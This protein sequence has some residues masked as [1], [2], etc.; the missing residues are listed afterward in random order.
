[1]KG[2]AIE[3]DK[4]GM[5]HRGEGSVLEVRKGLTDVDFKNM[6]NVRVAS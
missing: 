4:A 1:M 3:E 5:G 2:E 6:R